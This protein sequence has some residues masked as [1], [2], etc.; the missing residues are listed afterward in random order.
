MMHNRRLLRA[1]II[2]FALAC[3]SDGGSAV[4]GPP[5]AGTTRN[6]D[7]LSFLRVSPTA[8][9]SL[10]A[11]FWAVRGENREVR[12]YYVPDPASGDTS[13]TEFLRFRVDAGSLVAR[14][15]GTPFADR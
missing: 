3:G 12:M 10:T 6:D 11:S 2:V 15:D 14:P 5:P 9:T 1:L 7:Q 13:P 4:T 8:L